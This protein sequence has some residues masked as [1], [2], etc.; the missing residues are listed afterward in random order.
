M[1]ALEY[2]TG[3][4]HARPRGSSSASVKSKPGAAAV[5]AGGVGADSDV[6]G[7]ADTKPKVRP[8]GSSVSMLYVLQEFGRKMQRWSRISRES[9]AAY[10]KKCLLSFLR[11][12]RVKCCNRGVWFGEKNEVCFS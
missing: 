2:P 11:H 5:A 12:Q 4:S 3:F 7:G 9:N 10:G 1:P 8:D 6:G